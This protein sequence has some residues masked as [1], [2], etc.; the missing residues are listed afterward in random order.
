MDVCGGLEKLDY[1]I[2]SNKVIRDLRVLTE[3][4]QLHFLDIVTL[5][6]IDNKIYDKKNLYLLEE[7]SKNYYFNHRV[8]DHAIKNLDIVNEFFLTRTKL[9]KELQSI[10]RKWRVYKD[11]IDNLC[12]EKYL[13]YHNCPLLQKENI[14]KDLGLELANKGGTLQYLMMRCLLEKETSN[15]LKSKIKKLYNAAMILRGQ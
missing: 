12:D 11:L 15:Y 13:V 4:C 14:I 8:R 5:S 10:I 7:V 3:E 2:E 9:R 6:A 1:V